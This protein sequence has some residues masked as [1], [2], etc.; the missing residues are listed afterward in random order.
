MR[1]W[2]IIL[3]KCGKGNFKT[4][5]GLNRTRNTHL[6]NNKNQIFFF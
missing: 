5:D 3:R 2:K 1:V 4:E 6:P